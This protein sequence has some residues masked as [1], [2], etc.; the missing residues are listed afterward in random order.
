ME[1]RQEILR[2]GLSALAS[3]GESQELAE[4]KIRK[5]KNESPN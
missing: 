4:L 5:L 1:N 3:I 2:D